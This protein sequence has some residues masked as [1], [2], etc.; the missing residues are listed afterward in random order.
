[1]R[2]VARLTAVTLAATLWAAVVT[3]QV[4]AQFIVYDPTNYLEA[5]AQVEQLLR[6]YQFLVRQARRV[7]VDLATRYHAHSLEWTAHNLG[8]GLVYAR[9]L[10]AALNEG[11]ATGR[12]YRG[13]VVPLDLPNDV[14]G[15]MPEAMQRR[16]RSVYGML[17]W[18]DSA[19]QLAVDQTGTARGEGP[20]TLQAVRNVEHDIANP[21][22]D[23]HSQTA[24]L[25]KINAALAIDV[26]LNLINNQFA[27]SA[28]EQAVVATTRQRDTEAG[29][30]NATIHQWRYGQAYG[31]DLFSRT[32]AAIDGWRPY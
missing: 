14:V 28:L 10:L 18:V 30:M 13:T 12:A 2:T 1:M 25:E 21:G 24:L 20:F 32:A 26:R 15:R 16:L 4:H 3:R 6:Q 23:F 8:A 19:N 5:V 9:N 22:D 29:L 11:D 31:E 7:P 27:V 17:E